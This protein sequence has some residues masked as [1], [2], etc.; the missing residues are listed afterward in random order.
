[1]TGEGRGRD[2]AAAAAA[3]SGSGGSCRRRRRQ[4]RLQ[5]SDPTPAATARHSRELQ[6]RAV[7]LDLYYA[8]P[9]DD[10]NRQGRNHIE[11]YEA[12]QRQRWHLLFQRDPRILVCVT[13]PKV[14]MC[15][16]VLSLLHLKHLRSVFLHIA[17]PVLRCHLQCTHELPHGA[18]HLGKKPCPARVAAPSAEPAKHPTI[19]VDSPGDYHEAATS[20]SCAQRFDCF[21]GSGGGGG[22]IDEALRRV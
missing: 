10:A 15:R 17:R 21:G 8:L 3:A 7:A 19:P 16:C 11:R 5:R 13:Q 20:G 6:Q 14:R 18:W 12:G 1:M 4:Q 22:G 2:N 9:V